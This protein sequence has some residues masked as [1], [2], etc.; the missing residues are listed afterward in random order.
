MVVGA[1]GLAPEPG[2]KGAI[3]IN[4]EG[5]RIVACSTGDGSRRSSQLPPFLKVLL[6]RQM[7]AKE[8]RRDDP[9]PPVRLIVFG[10]QSS[11]EFPEVPLENGGMKT[12]GVVPVR[13]SVASKRVKRDP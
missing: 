10:D 3:V 4:L 9:C 5:E 2:D 8:K 12:L 11:K 7:T 13:S 1:L 6:C